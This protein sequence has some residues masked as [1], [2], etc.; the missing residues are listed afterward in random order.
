MV[1]QIDSGEH[2][3]AFTTLGSGYRIPAGY[4]DYEALFFNNSFRIAPTVDPF[5]DQLTEFVLKMVRGQGF[6][7]RILDP[8]NRNHAVEVHIRDKYIEVFT[9]L[10]KTKGLAQWASGGKS[11][12]IY[13]QNINLMPPQNDRLP[14]GYWD[15]INSHVSKAIENDEEA[16]LTLV[17]GGFT[18]RSRHKLF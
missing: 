1:L 7:D 15:Y 16:D 11:E 9:A 10:A 18:I 12:K 2:K 14:G 17:G 13:Y 3:L 6:R 5:R 4:D 8:N